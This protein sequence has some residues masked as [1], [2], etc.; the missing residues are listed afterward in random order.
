MSERR[1][2]EIIGWQFVRTGTMDRVIDGEWVKDSPTGYWMPPDCAYSD[3]S[4]PNVD[5]L[6]EWL[7]HRGFDVVLKA[8][9]T[10]L[11]DV[12]MLGERREVAVLIQTPDH[13]RCEYGLTPLAALE[14]AVRA[15][16][17]AEETA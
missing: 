4:P 15:V 5:D 16:A 17:V 12:Q 8:L 7:L 2:A 1:I 14:A 3:G 13:S 9:R 6:V 10:H 11:D